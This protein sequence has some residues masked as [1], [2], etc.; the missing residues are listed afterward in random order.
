MILTDCLTDIKTRCNDGEFLRPDYARYSFAQIPSFVEVLLGTRKQDDHPLAETLLRR[1]S[2]RP[3]NVVL[4]L[5]DGFGY[6][7]W[8]QYAN[9]HP[10]FNRMLEHGALMPITALFP[11]TT[12]ASVTTINSGLTPQEHGLI[13]WHL[14][15]EELD[16][17][18]YTLPF[19]TLD[20]KDQPDS[21]RKR[22]VDPRVLF[23]GTSLYTRLGDRGVSSHAFLRDRYA[24]SAY[25]SVAQTGTNVIR[26]SSAP[27]MLVHLRQQLAAAKQRSYFYVYWDEVDHLSHT[28]EPH[29]EPYLAELNGLSHLLQTEFLDKVDRHAAERTVFLVT[30]DHGHVVMKPNETIYL[31]QWPEVTEALAKSPAGKTIHPWG[32]ARDVFLKVR[33]DA[34]DGV[35]SFLSDK[36][37]GK[38]RVVRSQEEADS[39]LFGIGKE[40][41]QFRKRIGNVLV[42]PYEEYA[43][44]Y[45]YPGHEKSKHRGMHGGLS[46]EEMLT[47]LGFAT[48]SD[49]L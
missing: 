22:G 6:N 16:E 28:Y 26:Y 31:N 35:I 3:Q 12:A 24:G 38:A 41:P 37:A 27:D 45:Q 42:L 15:L 29:S 36:L 34:V 7:Q 44:W 13:E 17:I 32:N 25:S 20:A 4:L 23:S 39:G 18:I 49:L 8:L 14:Y 19:T 33:D 2:S 1:V 48:L 47:V 46:R 10:F 40:H 11:S 5:I 9:R 21:L 43:V 30:A